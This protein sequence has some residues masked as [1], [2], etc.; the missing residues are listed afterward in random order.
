MA[1]TRAATKNS[2]QKMRRHFDGVNVGVVFE[3][4]IIELPV[5]LDYS[6]GSWSGSQNPRF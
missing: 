3:F 5:R 2:E 1:A 6:I 4:V